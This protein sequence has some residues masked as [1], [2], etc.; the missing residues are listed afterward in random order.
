MWRAAVGLKLALCSK[1]LPP[2]SCLIPILDGSAAPC[3][4][5]EVFLWTKCFGIVATVSDDLI[6]DIPVVIE[7]PKATNKSLHSVFPELLAADR[8]ALAFG[9]IS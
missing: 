7:Q 3:S 2:L 4:F 9:R 8:Y 6:L 1:H 5:A